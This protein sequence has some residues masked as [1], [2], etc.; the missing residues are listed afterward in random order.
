M[1]RDAF[2]FFVLLTFVGCVYWFIN[3]SLPT[4]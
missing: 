1:N 4:L 2:W 3:Y